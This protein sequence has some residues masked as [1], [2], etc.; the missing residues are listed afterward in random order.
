MLNCDSLRESVIQYLQTETEVISG[1][2]YCVLSLPIRVLDGAFAEVYVEE[3]GPDSFLVHDGGRTIGHLESSGV[4]V[5]E[6]RQWALSSLADRM[7]ISLEDGVFKALAKR[8]NLQDVAFAVGQCC[9]IG[10]YDLVKH[11]PFAEEERIR[12][13]A[14]EEMEQWSRNHNVG[15]ERNIKVSGSIGRQYT[16]DFLTENSSGPAVAISLLLPSYGPMVAVDRFAAQVLDLKQSRRYARW[17]RVAVLAK[18]E[19]WKDRQRKIVQNLADEVAVITDPSE[20]FL[21]NSPTSIQDAID[22]VRAA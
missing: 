1:N 18:P 2:T 7:G 6:S 19:K 5:A 8:N 12:S 22:R 10:V 11:V 13:K 4:I 3:I 16:I 17:K 15:F 14:L 21:L 20:Q 9:S